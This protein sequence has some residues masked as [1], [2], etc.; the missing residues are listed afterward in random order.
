MGLTLVTGGTGTLGRNVAERLEA[1][2]SNT[3]VLSRRPA[4][5]DRPG[6]AWA[7]G[8]PRTGLGIQAAVAGADVIVHCATGLTGDVDAARHL[9]DAARGAGRPHLVYISIVGIDRLPA[10]YYK[11]KLAVERLVEKS[12]LP[13]TV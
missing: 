11:S 13:W 8:D 4:P 9:I 6:S 1:T 7:T 3:R 5:A 12:G 2:G 10:G